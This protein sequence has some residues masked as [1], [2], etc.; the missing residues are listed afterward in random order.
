MSIFTFSRQENI[1]CTS[2]LL[3]SWCNAVA[4]N[5]TRNL[6]N[7]MS[8][9]RYCNSRDSFSLSLS[10]AMHVVIRA[11]PGSLI[12]RIAEW[13][14]RTPVSR[15]LAKWLRT[16]R[17]V[18]SRGCNSDRSVLSW[19]LVSMAIAI[20]RSTQRRRAMDLCRFSP[21]S[22]S[23]LPDG[24]DGCSPNFRKLRAPTTSRQTDDSPPVDK[25]PIVFQEIL[26][27]AFRGRR[28][29]ARNSSFPRNKSAALPDNPLGRTYVMDSIPLDGFTRLDGFSTIASK[30]FSRR[31]IFFTIDS[32]FARIVFT[33]SKS[34][35]RALRNS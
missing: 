21:L 22:L 17:V 33:H 31:A 8:G 24:D 4:F 6:T 1:I 32:F 2:S 13:R 15:N 11:L 23:V 19:H 12:K 5:G 34:V 28:K 29:Y 14:R 35:R 27:R 30:I 18:R 10:L 20:P 3:T 25:P 7:N 26:V 16:R 9:A